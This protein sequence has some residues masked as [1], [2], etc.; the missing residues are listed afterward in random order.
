[1]YL[2]SGFEKKILSTYICNKF[3]GNG[4]NKSLCPTIR[5]F[6]L[7]SKHHGGF[8]NWPSKYSWNWNAWDTGPHRDLISRY[9]K[10]EAVVLA[11]FIVFH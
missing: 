3:V 4:L 1:M 7:T 2:T 11:Q 5:Y 10:T 8:T 9:C 6:V